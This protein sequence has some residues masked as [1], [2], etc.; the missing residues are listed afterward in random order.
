[1]GSAVSGPMLPFPL[2]W[3]LV[4]V[5]LLPLCLS[6]LTTTVVT[7]T[8]TVTILYFWCL[9]HG[10]CT[11]MCIPCSPLFPLPYLTLPKT[12]KISDQ[13]ETKKT[14]LYKASIVFLIFFL[15]HIHIFFLIVFF[16]LFLFLKVRV[17][18]IYLQKLNSNEKVVARVY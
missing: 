4:P 5:V 15:F 2:S 11:H 17:F 12:R 18:I 6:I 3:G 9:E 13:T 8:T 7:S 10:T 1:M 14:K 16:F